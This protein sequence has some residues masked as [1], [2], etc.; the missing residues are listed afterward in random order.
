MP[1]RP[2]RANERKDNTRVLTINIAGMV[3]EEG[4]TLKALTDIIANSNQLYFPVRRS[5]DGWYVGMVSI[6]N[7][8]N[9]MFE[10]DLHDLVVV[11]ESFF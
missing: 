11:K 9:W 5:S 4:T 7:V 10:S 3:L 6:H 2:A 1:T 8:R